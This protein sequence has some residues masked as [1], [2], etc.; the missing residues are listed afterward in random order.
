MVLDQDMLVK[1][2]AEK[3]AEAL[4]QI[5]ALHYAQDLLDRDLAVIDM[6]LPER[7]ALRMNP[8]AAETYQIRRAVAAVGGEET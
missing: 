1:L 6:R 8:E 2:P 5:M 3:S 4:K 7:P